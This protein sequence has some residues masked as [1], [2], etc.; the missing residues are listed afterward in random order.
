MLKKSYINLVPENIV[1]QRLYYLRSKGGDKI[2]DVILTIYKPVKNNDE[3]WSCSYQITEIQNNALYSILGVDA[4][5]SFQLALYIIDGLLKSH[6]KENE[7]Q[8]VWFDDND[9][10]GLLKK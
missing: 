10:L 4:L 8:I 9:D 6:N 1:A 3:E 7:N 5:Q 2:K